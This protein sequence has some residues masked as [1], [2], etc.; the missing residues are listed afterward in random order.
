MEER[1]QMRVVFYLRC[2]DKSQ[3][4]ENQRLALDGW[5]HGRG[6]RVVGTYV[7]SQSAWRSGH[8]HELAKL[9]EHARKG[10]FDA[11]VVWALDRLSRE[12][13]RVILS[14]VHRLAGYGV[15]TISFKE[16]W[17]EAPGELGE[18][19]YS[20]AGWVAKMESRRVSERTLAGLDRAKA[21]G[22][23][24]GRPPG[25]KDKRKRKKRS[26]ILKAIV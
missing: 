5:A 1:Q 15:R 19:L 9:L 25:A 20:I 7:E 6:W 8:Q 22:K 16:S 13:S 23:T 24:L 11:V 10:K 26:P 17:T 14:L 18:L 21:Q 12:G 3:E 4:M 2:S